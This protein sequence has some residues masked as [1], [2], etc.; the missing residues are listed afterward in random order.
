MEDAA[1]AEISRS[2]L[3]QWLRHGA[4][5]DTGR[6][7]T[8]VGAARA[9]GGPEC[10][11]RR[12]LTRQDV[13]VRGGSVGR[14]QAWIDQLLDEETSKIA[15][16]MGKDKVRHMA[17]HPSGQH[18]RPLTTPP[19]IFLPRDAASKRARSLPPASLR[20]H[21]CVSGRHCRPTALWTF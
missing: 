4:R 10:G 2:Q 5:T 12:A 11:I 13:G 18:G 14:H 8:K 3:W 6:V 15:T 17:G 16:S 7:V 21:A 20:S 9:S 19:V 1:T